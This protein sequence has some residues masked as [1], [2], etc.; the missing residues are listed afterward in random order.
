MKQSQLY[1]VLG[2]LAGWGAP[3]G[4][5]ALRYVFS[6]LSLPLYEFIGK[7]WAANSFFY[8]YMLVGTCLVFSLMGVI[9]GRQADLEVERNAERIGS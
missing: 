5:L 1:A 3:L 7:E 2:F 9:L 4:A 8:W 6:P